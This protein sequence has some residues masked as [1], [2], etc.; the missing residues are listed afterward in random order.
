MKLEL[1]FLILVASVH[2][3]ERL[4]L[5]DRSLK[6]RLPLW[7]HQAIGK[8]SDKPK[9]SLLTAALKKEDEGGRKEK[10]STSRESVSPGVRP[11][12]GASS[13]ASNPLNM[14]R[15]SLQSKRPSTK[16]ESLR[17]RRTGWRPELQPTGPPIQRRVSQLSLELAEYQAQSFERKKSSPEQKL[18]EQPRSGLTSE[19]RRSHNLSF[20]SS[21]PQRG[22][23]PSTRTPSLS[24]DDSSFGT[25]PF[26][27]S[28][29]SLGSIPSLGSLS[30]ASRSGSGSKSKRL[31]QV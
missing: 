29:S 30:D 19:Q 14:R 25:P 11:Q 31:T 13:S 3:S 9:T 1:V 6:A 26:A 4:G 8:R 15:L 12:P 21:S 27:S 28:I 10:V 24:G 23:S 7:N 17:V 20:G 2:A 5:Y 18:E 22:T 16:S